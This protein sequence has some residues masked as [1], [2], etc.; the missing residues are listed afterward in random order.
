VRGKAERIDEL[1]GVRALAIV[2][3]LIW[4]Y[5]VCQIF[6]EGGAWTEVKRVLATTW[7]GVDLFFVLSGFLIGGILID[8]RQAPN[9]LRV[10]FVRRACRILPLYLAVVG[11]FVAFGGAG[12]AYSNWLFEAPMPEFSYLTFTQNFFMAVR[13]SFGPHWLGVTWSLA[14][15]EQFYLIIPF[16]L[17]LAPR[18]IAIIVLVLFAA[19]APFLRA[20]LD[21]LD[22][23]V[24]PLSRADALLLGVLCA[25]FV[26]HTVWDVRQPWWRAGLIVL[27]VGLGGL[28][29]WQTLVA[30][31]IGGAINHLVFALFYAAFILA[32]LAWRG[33]RLTTPLRAPVAKWI[34][35]RSYAIYLLHQLVS[36]TMHGLAFDR[37]PVMTD[38]ASVGVTLASLALTL[39]LAELSFRVL[40]QPF[41]KLGAR[42]RYTAFAPP[43]GPAAQ[44][45]V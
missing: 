5:L 28:F 45:A 37:P 2:L 36:G 14:I 44:T 22:A 10:F 3:V 39:I 42:V 35:G 25:F 6:P 12:L 21:R 32:A 33:S 34:G 20:G 40:E 31:R 29:A 27:L 38:A 23:Y 24:L 18:R 9:A 17:V 7:S 43:A 1:D 16:V 41:L 26:R 19:A 11:A 8:N 30:P 13:E 15:E 4:H